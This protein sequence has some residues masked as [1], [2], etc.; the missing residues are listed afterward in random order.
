MFDHSNQFDKSKYCYGSDKLVVG[1]MKEETA[2]V[3]IKEFIGLNSKMF[4][5]L[6]NDS[7]KHRKEK[8]YE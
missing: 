5:V 6:V 8:G 1:K 4:S 7:S 3:A 2:G